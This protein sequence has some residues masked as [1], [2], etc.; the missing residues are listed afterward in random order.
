MVVSSS[1]QLPPEPIGPVVKDAL[2]R[3]L[4]DEVS[5]EHFNTQYLQKHST[6]G[7]AILASAKVSRLLNAPADQVES[8]VFAVFN[9]ETAL[10][11]KVELSTVM[12][13][14]GSGSADPL[15]FQTALDGFAFLQDAKSSRTDEFRS[16]CDSRFELSTVFK[17]PSEQTALRWNAAETD[18]VNGGVDKAEVVG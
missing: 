4:P 5:L 1:P 7:R 9:P 16:Q 13:A 6:D 12:L 8:S 17:T 11:L 18:A 3:L 2:A 14:D 15:S 10:D